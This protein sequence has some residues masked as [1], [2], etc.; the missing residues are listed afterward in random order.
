[1]IKYI[2][3][4]EQ[5]TEIGLSLRWVL[6]RFSGR[7]TPKTQVGYLPGCLIPGCVDWN[8]VGVCFSRMSVVDVPRCSSGNLQ[9]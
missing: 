2:I 6:A 5:E 3:T 1:M 9:A 8:D 7:F 4:V